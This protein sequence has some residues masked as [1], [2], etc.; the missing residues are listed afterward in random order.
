MYGIN[1]TQCP[2][3]KPILNSEKYNLDE[4][5][6][7]SNAVVAVISYTGYD[8]EDA[9]IL[10]KASVE[11]G[12]SHGWIQKTH[13]TNLRELAKDSGDRHGGS[14]MSKSNND[15]VKYLFGRPP[16][17]TPGHDVLH[18][19]VNKFLDDDG[20]PITGSKVTYGDP[21]CC[22]YEVSTG[23]IRVEEYKSTEQAYIWDVKLLGSD[24]G[25]S[26]L[27]TIAITLY[28]NR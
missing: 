8:M 12:F 3:V 14:T 23:T 7:G 4:Y 22:Y 1:Y 13:V 15:D 25:Q 26:I 20:L 27:Q 19:K 6:M 16:G 21:L 18:G 9:L 17:W 28:I 5:P 10:N 24:N 11:R 2:L